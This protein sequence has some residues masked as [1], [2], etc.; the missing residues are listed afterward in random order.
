VQALDEN[1]YKQISGLQRMGDQ[2]QIC[3]FGGLVQDANGYSSTAGKVFQ[4]KFG[5]ITKK[6]KK[7]CS[8]N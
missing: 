3:N 4:S 5:Q 7:S 1:E 6:E 2:I 8:K